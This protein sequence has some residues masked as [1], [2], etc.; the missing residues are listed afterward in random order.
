M[1]LDTCVI[2]EMPPYK[3]TSA[4]MYSIFVCFE[5]FIAKTAPE[6]VPSA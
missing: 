1:G 5:I 6:K 2:I 3:N 4:T